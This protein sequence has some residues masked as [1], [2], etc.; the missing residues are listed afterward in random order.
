MTE[1]RLSFLNIPSE[2]VRV[3]AKPENDTDYTVKPLIKMGCFLSSCP[4]IFEL[5]LEND[6]VN[7]A[8]D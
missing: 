7:L 2:R 4:A 3:E 5:N 8:N 1:F 6:I